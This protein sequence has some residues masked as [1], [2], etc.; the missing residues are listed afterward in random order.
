M[1]FAKFFH[2]LLKQKKT[3]VSQYSKN[4]ILLQYNKIKR[5]T[6]KGQSQ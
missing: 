3:E 2:F 6:K 5:K 1:L 4:I